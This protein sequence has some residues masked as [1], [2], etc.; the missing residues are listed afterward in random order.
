MKLHTL[1]IAALLF[2]GSAGAT[3][4]QQVPAATNGGGIGDLKG[5]GAFNEFGKTDNSDQG[6]RSTDVYTH[7]WYCDTSVPAKS[8][9]GCE[10]GT[11]YNK[12]PAGQFDALYVTVPLGFAVPPMSMDCPSGLVCVDHPVTI[13]LSAIGMS[14]NALLPGHDHFTTTVNAGKPEWWNVLVV[15]VKDART[16]E[17]IKAHRSFAYIERL[18]KAGNKNVTKPLP[19][20]LFL[21]FAVR[22]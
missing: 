13:D 21:Y 2:G 14:G 19:T 9:S 20:N 4:A 6:Q 5:G 22:P 18:I 16:Y 11:T 17:D 3:F 8:T 7:A 15:G 1:A 10:L 12:P